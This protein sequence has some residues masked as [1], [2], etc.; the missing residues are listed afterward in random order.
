MDI[1]KTCKF[2]KS[3]VI[4]PSICTRISNVNLLTKRNEQFS[5]PVS[6]K[7]CKG[8]F[9]EKKDDD[10]GGYIFEGGLFWVMCTGYDELY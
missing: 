1:C 2:Y 7:I 10:D 5:L 3:H 9:Y 8:Y 4:K 6:F